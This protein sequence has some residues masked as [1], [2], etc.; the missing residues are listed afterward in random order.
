MYIVE[1]RVLGLLCFEMHAALTE[2]G[3]RL[4]LLNN[5]ND[6]ENENGCKC[7]LEESLEYVEKTMKYLQYEP[8]ILSE[9]QIYAQAK[10]NR[11]SL[12]L[13]LGLPV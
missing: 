11:D 1:V 2:R 10:I 8:I 5:T 12:K 3:R 7:A 4:A 13:V 6:N 9:G